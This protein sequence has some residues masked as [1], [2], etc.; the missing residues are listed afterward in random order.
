MIRG[1]TH[2]LRVSPEHLIDDVRVGQSIVGVVWDVG[3]HYCSLRSSS[4][5]VSMRPVPGARAR[6]I[7]C[8]VVGVGIPTLHVLDEDFITT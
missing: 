3:G 7:A 4:S 1:T 6:L 8:F 5:A 2:Q